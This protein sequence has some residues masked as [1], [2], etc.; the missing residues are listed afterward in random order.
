MH[1][2]SQCVFFPRSELGHNGTKTACRGELGSAV[3]VL[4]VLGSS[5]LVLISRI[6]V[7]ILPVSMDGVANADGPRGNRLTVST[8]RLL[9][10]VVHR[11]LVDNPL[12]QGEAWGA[13]IN[14]TLVRPL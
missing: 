10:R 1:P 13:E 9:V 3:L 12:H 14:D 11:R 2:V 6:H 8:L 4:M 5:I 7:D